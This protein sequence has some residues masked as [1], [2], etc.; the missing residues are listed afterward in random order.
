MAQRLHRTSPSG[1]AG[2]DRIDFQL[3]PL[4]V[5][6]LE[7]RQ[8]LFRRFQD[9]YEIQK[10]V[11]GAQIPGAENW[12]P[13]NDWTQEGDETAYYRIAHS[14]HTGDMYLGEKP[15]TATQ[16]HRLATQLVQALRALQAA[17]GRPHGDLLLPNGELNRGA[18]VFARHRGDDFGRLLLAW[19][20]PP[21]DVS[22]PGMAQAERADLRAIGAFVRALCLD[23]PVLFGKQEGRWA[24]LL[25]DLADPRPDLT[26]DAVASRLAAL[27]PV[28]RHP[29]LWLL[30]LFAMLAAAGWF[31][32]GMASA[33]YLFDSTPY[34]RALAAWTWLAGVE[35]VL[36]RVA[37]EERPPG[38]ALR[39]LLEL[40]GRRHSW[41][42]Y[43]I[44]EGAEKDNVEGMVLGDNG[45]LAA[46][47]ARQIR[48]W[49]RSAGGP[50][51]H[52]L[53]AL[54]TDIGRLESFFA[55]GSPAGGG[56]ARRRGPSSPPVARGARLSRTTGR[57]GRHRFC[58]RQG[59][60]ARGGR[61]RTA[62]RAKN[63][64]QP[65]R[66]RQPGRKMGGGHGEPSRCR[67]WWTG[68]TTSPPVAPGWIRS[69]AWS[70][71]G[72]NSSPTPPTAARSNRILA[73]VESEVEAWDRLIDAGKVP[74]FEQSPGRQAHGHLRAEGRFPPQARGSTR[75]SS[76]N[77]SRTSPARR[78]SR[79]GGGG[80]RATA[81]RRPPLR[82][83]TPSGGATATSSWARRPRR[84]ATGGPVS[85][86]R[87]PRRC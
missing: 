34:Y 53:D 73:A 29:V 23:S 25:R 19:P 45:R 66:H 52:R 72:T 59:Q 70:M 85:P 39:S 15:F 81:T 62:R 18:F 57:R 38:D 35:E 13:V 79:T 87:R 12:L 82:A 8:M 10:R 69:T 6:S 32:W 46:A 17:A 56:S 33:R 22:G 65:E 75:C 20:L 30:P 42:A 1:Q 36:D 4:V 44:L 68:W 74:S 54:A 2:F 31:G 40:H 3:P 28:R 16:C 41:N 78:E 51:R 24:D 26:L 55:G 77:G 47:D 49:V 7:R 60:V 86:I 21:E 11:A 67:S 48:R 9:V 43:E 83:S 80:W 61:G 76:R 84:A 63:R 58:R 37:G 71:S 5:S 14:D 64:R 27:R 50:A